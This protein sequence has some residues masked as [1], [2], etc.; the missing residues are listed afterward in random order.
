MTTP[1]FGAEVSL[2]RT[3]LS[4]NA[5]GASSE[6]PASA[7]YPAQAGGGELLGT[8]LEAWRSGRRPTTVFEPCPPNMV[9]TWVWDCPPPDPSECFTLPN[10][11]WFCLIYCVYQGH[12]EC[13]PRRLTVFRG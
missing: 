2:Y 6:Q 9:N 11:T 8:L 1:G 5:T 7:V 13:Q 12:Y 4:Y 10:G 3:S